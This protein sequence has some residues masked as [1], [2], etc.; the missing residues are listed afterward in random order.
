[1]LGGRLALEWLDRFLAD[2]IATVGEQIVP[3]NTAWYVL[4]N[5][6]AP[7]VGAGEVQFW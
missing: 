6:T 2:R 5:H 1:M 4:I 7:A 3:P